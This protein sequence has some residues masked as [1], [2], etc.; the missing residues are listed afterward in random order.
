MI[1]SSSSSSEGSVITAKG[2]MP[3]GW[4]SVAGRWRA[5]G[6][7]RNA[8]R[9]WWSR[10]GTVRRRW[11]RGNAVRRG[12]SR[13]STVRRWWCRW[14][15]V[16]IRRTYVRYSVRSSRWKTILWTRWC[17][18]NVYDYYK[19]KSIFL[20]NVWLA[21]RTISSIN[22]FYVNLLFLRS[23]R[24]ANGRD[25]EKESQQYLK[26]R[27]IIIYVKVVDSSRIKPSFYGQLN[28]SSTLVMRMNII[29]V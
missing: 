7:G 26:T 14:S 19:V 20:F 28:V 27:R 1:A 12:W 11:S 4:G 22:Y 23:Y 6:R 24:I 13:W 25:D 15:S 17:P 10:R 3:G 18:K 29:D 16:R 9:R 8:I 5:V 2:A 21:A